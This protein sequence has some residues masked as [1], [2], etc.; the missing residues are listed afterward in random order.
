MGKVASEWWTIPL[1]VGVALLLV[2]SA[3]ALALWLASPDEVGIH[4]LLRLLPDVL[5]L[6]KRLATDPQL[7][8]RIRMLLIVLLAFLAS[9]ID[10]IPDFIPVIGFA[11]DIVVTVLVLR[12]VTRTAGAEAL[13]RHWTGTPEGLAALRRVCGVP[14]D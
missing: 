9:P 14:S 12:W 8:R 3:I 5:R 13:A 4:D 6:I 10:L 1:G 7:P 11:D 2:W